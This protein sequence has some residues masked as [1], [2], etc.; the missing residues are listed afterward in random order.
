MTDAER[1]AALLRESR[2]IIDALY[3]DA[4]LESSGAT[5]VATPTTLDQAMRDL[6]IAMQ[7][8]IADGDA[9]QR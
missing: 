4:K 8:L 3:E 7:E 2:A 6:A 9:P 5:S 1:T